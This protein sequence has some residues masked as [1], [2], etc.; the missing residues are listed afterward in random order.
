MR[1]EDVTHPRDERG[2]IM[3]ERTFLHLPGVGPLTE[4]R[5]WKSGFL[6]WDDLGSAIRGGATVRDL[7][8]TGRRQASLFAVEALP[9]DRRSKAWLAC[10]DASRRALEDADFQ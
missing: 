4:N 6:C 3:I 2:V 9:T 1:G 7:F 8:R 10:L 5:L